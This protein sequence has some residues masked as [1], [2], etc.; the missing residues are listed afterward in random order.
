MADRKEYLKQ[1][2]L[3]NKEHI[4]Q[5]TVDYYQSKKDDTLAKH[6]LYNQ[7]NKEK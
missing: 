2:R 3:E 4:K 5:Y 7:A 6:K 1:W